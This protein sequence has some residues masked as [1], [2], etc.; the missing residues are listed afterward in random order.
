MG[1]RYRW[2]FS[3]PSWSNNG[4]CDRAVVH[5][6]DGR[7]RLRPAL[8]G[9]RLREKAPQKGRRASR[10]VRSRLGSQSGRGCVL[11]ALVEG[12]LESCASQISVMGVAVAAARLTVQY[13][14]SNTAPSGLV[15]QLL[16]PQE[17]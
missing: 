2:T 4:R 5:A 15:L 12:T 14:M 6:R 3:M 10:P 7:G 11:C 13:G 16:D 8:Q 9:L 17:S 1:Q